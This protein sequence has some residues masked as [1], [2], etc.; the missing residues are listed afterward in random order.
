[1]FPPGGAEVDTDGDSAGGQGDG[2]SSD[3][4]ADGGV[5][6]VEI[7]EASAAYVEQLFDEYAVSFDAL[8][9]ALGY[10][11]PH[12]LEVTDTHTNQS[13]KKKSNHSNIR[14]YLT[15]STATSI[16]R[17]PLAVRTKQLPAGWG[18]AGGMTLEHLA[19]R[20]PPLKSARANDGRSEVGGLTC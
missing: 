11:V 12:L 4:I 3:S 20:S 5:R 18:A 1:M 16:S 15:H 8:V 7:S 14:F 6:A 13:S 10:R 2:V 17:R 19:A 9:D